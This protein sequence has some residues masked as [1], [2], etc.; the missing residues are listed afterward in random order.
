MRAEGETIF[1][2]EQCD[3]CHTVFDVP[4]ADGPT[5][6]PAA[7]LP[8][9]SDSRV[10]PDLGL[11]GHRR[12]D[13]WHAAH[14]YAP[15]VL[16]P[17]SRMPAS[18]HLFVTGG[19]L[20]PRLNDDGRALVAWLQGLGRARRDVWSEFRSQDPPVPV[21]AAVARAARRERGAALYAAWCVPCHG[22]QGD[23]RGP[24]AALLVVPPRDLTRAEFRFRSTPLGTP[25]ADADLFR[26]L[27]LGSGIGAAM[28]S[29][30]FLDAEDRW[31]LV[32]A[33]RTFAPA[34]RDAELDVTPAPAPGGAG[35]PPGDP[36]GSAA[37]A[38]AGAASGAGAALGARLYA[39]WGCAACHGAE[40]EGK[41]I[42]ERDRQGDA[43]EPVV[44]ASDL[45]HP[46]GRRAGGSVA[47]F[48]RALRLGVGPVMPAFAAVL[49]R[50]PQAIPALLAWLVSRASETGT[51]ERPAASPPA[52]EPPPA[53]TPRAL[54]APGD[55]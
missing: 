28:P 5:P 44:W 8:Q 20:P 38:G 39:A 51:A 21:P 16:V 9:P 10:G 6:L 25:A 30:T 11:E 45:R 43:P 36:S 31:A 50:E 2:R 53:V 23:G 15:D 22:V 41:R 55:R 27:T 49:D 33:V 12:S 1:R 40:G 48:E 32:Q 24:A 54:R 19:S 3:R 14:L 26:V 7:R 18:R 17:G 4:A 46:C 47:A 35:A 34:T 13:D 42:D 29:F 52:E 37:P